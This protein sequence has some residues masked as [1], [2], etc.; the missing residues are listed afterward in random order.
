[1]HATRCLRVIV[2]SKFNLIMNIEAIAR[3]PRD[4][5]SNSEASLESVIA[6]LA[7]LPLAFQ[8]GSRWH[9]SMSIDVP[10]HL[11]EVLSGRPR[12]STEEMFQYRMA[13]SDNVWKCVFSFEELA[14]RRQSFC[15]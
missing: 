10:A 5:L 11:I 6:E 1:M 9:Y 7:C 12:R 3:K 4:F 13:L 2:H 14:I 8:P 15:S